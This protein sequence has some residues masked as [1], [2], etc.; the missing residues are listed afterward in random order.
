MAR[1]RPGWDEARELV[2][3]VLRLSGV[4]SQ[5]DDPLF[6]THRDAVDDLAETL[7][8]AGVY[9]LTLELRQRVLDAEQKR[10][11]PEDRDVLI[12]RLALVWSL[13]RSGNAADAEAE[14][15]R[16]HR[17]ATTLHPDLAIEARAALGSEL[18]R[19]DQA[20]EAVEHFEAVYEALSADLGPTHPDTLEAAAELAAAFLARGDGWRA[21]A[22]HRRVLDA[23]MRTAGS[24]HPTTL[25]SLG[26]LSAALTAIGEHE[27]ATTLDMECLDRRERS[28]GPDH[29]STLLSA[30]YLALDHHDLGNLESALQFARRALAGQ[31]RVLGSEHPFTAES[32]RFVTECEEALA[33]SRPLSRLRARLRR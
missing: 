27:E 28:L 3:H 5:T 16:A 4:N 6:V 30:F 12:S 18:A 9:H 23:R 29:P 33:A 22:L 15:R 10:L 25:T 20:D 19:S 17:D 1:G 32:R 24:D 21:V 11:G 14:A 26:Q 13:G 31:E 7:Q 8:T 2:P